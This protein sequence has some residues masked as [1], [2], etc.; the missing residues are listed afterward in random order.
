M[1]GVVNRSKK[2][3]V[4]IQ[5]SGTE[6]YDNI[7]LGRSPLSRFYS[8]QLIRIKNDLRSQE[9]VK[10]L[11]EVSCCVWS[12]RFDMNEGTAWPL[13][14]Q[15]QVT[16]SLGS[17]SDRFSATMPTRGKWLLL[18][19]VE[20][21]QVR[22]SPEDS[23]VLIPVLC[24]QVWRRHFGLCHELHMHHC[25]RSLLHSLSQSNTHAHTQIHTVV[26]EFICFHLS[27]VAG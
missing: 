20:W 17:E 14:K 10:F 24:H 13:S 2:K 4:W 15:E 7:Y 5:G 23:H 9:C 22:R 3:D 21:G 6:V 1:D 26:T 19:R 16:V 11:T 18:Q 8:Q 12:L 25:A 27:S